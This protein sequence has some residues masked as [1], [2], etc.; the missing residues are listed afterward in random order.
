M[1][2]AIVESTQRA[3]EPYILFDLAGTTYGLHSRTV[4]QLEMVEHI[5]AVPNAPPFVEGVIFSRGQ[6]VPVVNL[7]RRFGFEKRPHDL[8]TRL[9][10]VAHNDRTV[11]LIVDAA[12]EFVAIAPA[13]IQPPPEAISGLSGKYLQSI[14]T[15]GERLVLILDVDEILN[16]TDFTTLTPTGA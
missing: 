7:R 10:V 14:A 15:L 13:A 5:T 2:T 12:R 3:A 16:F 4:Q 11:G 6:V 9:V 8:K 1:R